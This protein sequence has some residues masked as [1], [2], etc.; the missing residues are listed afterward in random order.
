[1]TSIT[2]ATTTPF[3]TSSECL[4]FLTLKTRGPSFKTPCT[5]ECSPCSQLPFTNN[6]QVH[7]LL[8]KSLKAEATHL[9]LH[10]PL[11]ACSNSSSLR[12]LPCPQTSCKCSALLTTPTSTKYPPML[13]SQEWSTHLVA[14]S[15]LPRAFNRSLSFNRSN[16]NKWTINFHNKG[17]LLPRSMRASSLSD[18]N[19]SSQFCLQRRKRKI[20]KSGGNMKIRISKTKQLKYSI[21]NNSQ[22]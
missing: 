10:S 18:R 8:P 5:S 14:S 16:L 13:T 3:P 11:K 17:T 21:R 15:F 2:H 4:T 22:N 19:P 6:Q 20:L 1:M 7:L 12:S 9:L